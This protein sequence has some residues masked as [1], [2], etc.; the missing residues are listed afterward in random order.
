MAANRSTWWSLYGPD[1]EFLGDMDLTEAVIRQ[2]LPLAIVTPETR[3]IRLPPTPVLDGGLV[4]D[5]TVW[6]DVEAD[7]D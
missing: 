7:H 4:A 5:T 6:R 2:T 3:T 1:G